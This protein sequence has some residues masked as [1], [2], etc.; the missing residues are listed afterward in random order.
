MS[1][2]QPVKIGKTAGEAAEGGGEGRI[3]YARLVRG[4]NGI[5]VTT[6]ARLGERLSDIG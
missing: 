5:I 6:G 1:S 4:R 2:F 3:L